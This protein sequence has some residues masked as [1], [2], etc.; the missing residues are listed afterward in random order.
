MPGYRVLVVRPNN[1][2]TLNAALFGLPVQVLPFPQCTL[3]FDAC[4]R[5]KP[6]LLFVNVESVDVADALE[7]VVKVRAIY[8]QL[9]IIMFVSHSSEELA[10][11][12]LNSGVTRYL[13]QPVTEETLA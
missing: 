5:T 4:A 12:A 10:I 9:P 3:A 13:R 6:D 7:F 11:A 8:Q 1:C 2:P